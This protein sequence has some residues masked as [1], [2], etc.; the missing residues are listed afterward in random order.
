MPGALSPGSAAIP[1]LRSGQ[2]LAAPDEAG[3]KPALPG[4]SAVSA[5]AYNASGVAAGAP[6]PSLP[7]VWYRATR[8]FSF[9]ASIIPI[10]V[11]GACALLAGGASPLNFLLCLGGAVA[12]QAGTHLVNDYYDPPLGAD[13]SGALGA[14]RGIQGGG[15]PPRA[16][17]LGGVALFFAGGG[18][19]E[20]GDRGGVALA[21]RRAAGRDRFFW[22]GGGGRLRAGEPGRLA[23]PAAGADRG[24]VGVRLHGP[25]AEAGVPWPGRA[26][27][28][29]ADGS[30]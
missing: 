8:P 13:H 14:G 22:G 30:P 3:W 16:G 26:E 10:L 24:A 27:R 1:S 15:V 23:D 19:A 11:G 9:T 17:L 18:G 6:R 4:E 5:E 20:R 2:A 25:A 28:L 21:A 12:L 7:V 29:H